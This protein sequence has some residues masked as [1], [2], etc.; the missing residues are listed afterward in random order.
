MRHLT[1]TLVLIWFLLL[2]SL[3]FGKN[4]I[5][6]YLDAK[7]SVEIAKMANESMRKRNQKMYTEIADL[8]KGLEAV[9]ERARH[10]LGLIKPN[11]TFFRIVE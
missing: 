7:H 9:E 11:E 8:R 3:S 4:G 2:Y 1:I 10:E 6:D 5:N